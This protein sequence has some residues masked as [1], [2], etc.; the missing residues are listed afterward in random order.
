MKVLLALLLCAGIFVQGHALKVLGFL[1]FMSKSHFA[2]G[3]AVLKS[4]HDVG[5]EITVVSPY[6]LKNPPVNYTD[7]STADILEEFL[8][9][10][11]D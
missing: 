2:I 9:R 10:N 6:P 7:I 11:Y 1:P 5:H 8:K 4:L 3:H